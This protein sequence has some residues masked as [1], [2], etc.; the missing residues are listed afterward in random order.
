MVSSLLDSF[1]FFFAAILF[2]CAKWLFCLLVDSILSGCLAS[3]T[4]ALDVEL[5][6]HMQWMAGEILNANCQVLLPL[7][8]Q[9]PRRDGFAATG[10]DFR[11]R[12]LTL[13]VV[14]EETWCVVAR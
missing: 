3:A 14:Q 13:L 9:L 11:E 10:D 8:L 7:P 4:A 12:E 2:L 1:D 5:D 6:M